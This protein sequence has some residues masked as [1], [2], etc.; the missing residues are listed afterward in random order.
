M[1]SG[2]ITSWQTGGGK[3]QT[4]ADVIFLGSSDCSHKVKR[5]LLLRRKAVTYLDS[6]VKNRAI[7]LP[8]KVQMVKAMVPVFMYG[9]ESWTIKTAECQRIEAFKLW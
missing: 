3:V 6:M 8:T 9:C 7:T 2:P 4:M 5:C 1:A